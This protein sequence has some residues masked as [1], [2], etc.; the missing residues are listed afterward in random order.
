MS[1][2]KKPDTYNLGHFARWAAAARGEQAP[3]ID[4]AERVRASVERLAHGPTIYGAGLDGGRRA[5]W[6]E[7]PW[8]MFAGASLVAAALVAAVALPAWESVQDPL[9]AFCRPFSNLLE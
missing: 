8:V 3:R 4:V 6:Q 2:P 1:E 5:A 7:S 9:V